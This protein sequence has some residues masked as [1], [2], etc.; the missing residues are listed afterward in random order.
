MQLIKR[1]QRWWTIQRLSTQ[2]LDILKEGTGVQ[3][4][5]W[6]QGS[7]IADVLAWLDA[8][9][10]TMARPYGFQAAKIVLLPTGSEN[11]FYEIVISQYQPY[12]AVGRAM[13]AAQL[14]TVLTEQDIQV[15]VLAIGT[16]L[17]HAVNKT[18]S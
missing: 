13:I 18:A 16:A 2:V 12:W 1:I 17:R 4:A 5:T 11:A 8:Q 15:V 10:G 6:V 14:Q 7:E 9:M 3:A